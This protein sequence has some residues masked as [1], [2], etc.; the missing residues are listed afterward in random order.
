MKL[1][2]C[3]LSGLVG[4]IAIG[5]ETGLGAEAVKR[6]LTKRGVK[7]SMSCGYQG[8]NVYDS[9]LVQ[10]VFRDFKKSLTASENGVG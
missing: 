1:A 10:D 9:C 7:A 4:V 6:I 3:E 2:C 8:C 5:I